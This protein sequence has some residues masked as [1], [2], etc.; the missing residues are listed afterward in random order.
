[1][2]STRL[3]IAGDINLHL[4]KLDDV[5]TARFNAFLQTID[6]VE[7][8]AVSTHDSWPSRCHRHWK[9][10]DTIEYVGLKM[11]AYEMTV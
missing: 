6:M 1:M 4:H 8:V 10:S 3:T 7:H 2:F 9:W 5:N 11:W